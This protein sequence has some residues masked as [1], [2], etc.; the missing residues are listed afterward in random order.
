MFPTSEF[1]RSSQC[2]SPI[3]VGSVS[4]LPDHP[5]S[6]DEDEDESEDELCMLRQQVALLT[7]S[8]EDEKKR[9]T[10]EQHLMQSKIIELQSLIRAN[11]HED[12]QEIETVEAGKKTM[13]LIQEGPVSTREN[14]LLLPPPAESSSCGCLS[15]S[16]DKSV[17]ATGEVQF[18]RIRARMHAIV[19]DSQRETQTLQAQLEGVKR[20]QNEREKRL[21]LETTIKVTALEQ[22][23]AAASTRLAQK[24]VNSAAQAKKLQADKVELVAYVQTQRQRLK[25]LELALGCKQLMD[26]LR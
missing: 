7:K 20:K 14:Q 5:I 9:R 16:N 17:E 15:K 6:S 25:Q 19:I 26:D 24:A 4:N 8:L 2:S 18:T 13:S 23:H 22:K 3:P 21:T 10:S 1:G 12:D 11:G